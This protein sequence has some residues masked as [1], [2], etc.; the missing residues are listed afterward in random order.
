MKRH[1]SAH[2]FGSI[3]DGRGTLSTASGALNDSPYSFGSRFLEGVGT[4]PE[5]LIAA[6]HAGCFAMALSA[7]LSKEGF[8]AIAIDAKATISIEKDGDTW[9]VSSSELVLHAR[10]PGL[11]SPR[12][13]ILAEDAKANCPISRL[14]NVPVTLEAHLESERPSVDV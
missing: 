4:N 12:F 11:S 3:N 8:S 1:A 7:N 5:E 13:Q 6:A 10:I 2:W 9:S 14:L